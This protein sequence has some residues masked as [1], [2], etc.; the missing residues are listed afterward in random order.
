MAKSAS[1]PIEFPPKGYLIAAVFCTLL[2]FVAVISALE[3]H[4]PAILLLAVFWAVISA[5]CVRSWK[6][7]R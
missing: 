6:A 3:V 1:T 4:K 7:T 5:I 2:G